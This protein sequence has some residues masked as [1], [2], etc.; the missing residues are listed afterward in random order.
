MVA[1]HHADHHDKSQEWDSTRQPT[2]STLGK[3]AGDERRNELV[4]QS[5]SQSASEKASDETGEP[6]EESRDLRSHAWIGLLATSMSLD[7]YGG[8]GATGER[9]AK[10]SVWSLSAIHPPR[11]F[12]R[13]AGRSLARSLARFT[14]VLCWLTRECRRRSRLRIGLLLMKMLLGRRR[15]A[16]SLCKVGLAARNY[17]CRPYALL[18]LL[19]SRFYFPASVPSLAER[20]RCGGGFR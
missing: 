1:G 5:V 13:T 18:R 20:C 10:Q 19:S 14:Y 2:E 11:M 4:S 12:L 17:V 6:R 9:G 15:R 3:R 7:G 16:V 8:R